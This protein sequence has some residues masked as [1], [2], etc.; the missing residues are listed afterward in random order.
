MGGLFGSS[1][2][3]GGGSSMTNAYGGNSQYPV[4]GLSASD[5]GTGY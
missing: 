5:Y 3:Y 4:A 1:P 2:Q